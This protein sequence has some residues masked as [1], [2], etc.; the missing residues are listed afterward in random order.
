MS[1]VPEFTAMDAFENAIRRVGVVAACEWFGYAADS[2]FTRESALHL[3]ERERA[4][5][6]ID[7]AMA[8]GEAR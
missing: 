3:Q 7:A 5:A 8:A 2:A 1:E 4:A 6:A